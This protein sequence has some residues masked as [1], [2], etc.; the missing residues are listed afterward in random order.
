MRPFSCFY[1][2][3][4]IRRMRGTPVLILQLGV[5][6]KKFASGLGHSWVRC[7]YQA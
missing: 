4:A 1:D 6:K 7:S 2:P 3:E 5:R